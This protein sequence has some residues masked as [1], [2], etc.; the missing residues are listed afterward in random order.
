MMIMIMME[1]EQHSNTTIRRK[2]RTQERPKRVI[3]C[4]QEY[5]AYRSRGRNGIDKPYA[6][7]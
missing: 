2:T 3:H 4:L 7:R 6:A 1:S 5:V